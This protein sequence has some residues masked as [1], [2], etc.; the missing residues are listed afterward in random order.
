MT[1][2]LLFLTALLYFT[3]GPENPFTIFYFVNLAL[4]AVLLLGGSGG[5]MDC[6]R[7]MAAILV[8]EGYAALAAR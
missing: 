1:L 5:G 7:R 8:H 6:A 2:D 4:A 3:G